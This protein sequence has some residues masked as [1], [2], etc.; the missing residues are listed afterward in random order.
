MTNGQQKL[1]NDAS[2]SNAS[3]STEKKK[4]Y[5]A[6]YYASRKENRQPKDCNVVSTLSAS[7]SAQKRKERNARYYASCK[8]NNKVLK[9]GVGDV[10]QSDPLLSLSS[11]RSI[12][13]IPLKTLQT[14]S[15]QMTQMPKEN[16]SC[17]QTPTNNCTPTTTLPSRINELMIE[18]PR[19]FFLLGNAFFI[20][21]F[22]NCR[23]LIR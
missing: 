11:N 10:S 12:E 2:T 16:V 21:L 14:N 19:G 23:H 22:G 18:I 6:Q 20:K 9:V 7:T 17:T 8:E 4:E 15:S 3:T 5:N 13:R 1:R